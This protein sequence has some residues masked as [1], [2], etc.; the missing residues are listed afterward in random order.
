M[1]SYFEK[2]LPYAHFHSSSDP[3]MNYRNF[4][5]CCIKLLLHLILKSTDSDLI[6]KYFQ[7]INKTFYSFSLTWKFLTKKGKLEKVPVLETLKSLFYD[8]YN[9]FTFSLG[10]VVF[11]PLTKETL[12]E[13]LLSLALS[14]KEKRHMTNLSKTGNIKRV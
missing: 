7:K 9:S 1:G 10:K 8:S 12:F 11:Y 2:S 5:L 6:Y 4:S 13:L 3:F 14:S